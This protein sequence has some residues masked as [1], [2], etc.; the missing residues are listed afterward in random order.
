[1]CLSFACFAQIGEVIGRFE[2]KGF[3]L[4]GNHA[5]LANDPDLCLRCTVRRLD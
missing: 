4:K 1:M 5:H 2:K 3:Y